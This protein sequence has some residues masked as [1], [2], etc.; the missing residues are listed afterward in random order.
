MRQ[1]RR[2]PLI[3]ALGRQRQTDLCEFEA[4]LVYRLSSRTSQDCSTEKPCLEKQKQNKLGMRKNVCLVYNRLYN[5]I[6]SI[7]NCLSFQEENRPEIV[8]PKF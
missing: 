4:T 6:L 2:T 8:L 1:W 3:L 7:I 5:P